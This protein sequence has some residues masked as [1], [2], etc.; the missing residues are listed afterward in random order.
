MATGGTRFPWQRPAHNIP[1][2]KKEKKMLKQVR[3]D[4]VGC[5]RYEK[6]EAVYPPTR[7]MPDYRTLRRAY[8]HPG[9]WEML[10]EPED[11]EDLL[12]EYPGGFKLVRYLRKLPLTDEGRWKQLKP[13]GGR[14]YALHIQPDLPAQRIETFKLCITRIPA[15][16]AK[17]YLHLPQNTF[18]ARRF[19]SRDIQEFEV[20]G[21]G[22]WD[23]RPNTPVV[24][25]DDDDDDDD[26]GA[27]GPGAGGPGAG[28]PGAGGPGAG[29]SGA[30]GSGA[31]GSGRGAGG[32]AVIYQYETSV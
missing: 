14:F 31:G 6:F 30:G 7:I 21:S 15:N 13:D 25:S 28:G 9:S 2:T 20:A 5:Q 4:E 3:R 32:K 26:D 19:A 27:G 24:S 1:Q 11:V 22:T 17:V 8:D 18:L 16:V 12:T 10:W 23:L 29:G